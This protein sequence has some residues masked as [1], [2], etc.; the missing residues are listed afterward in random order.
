[1]LAERVAGRGMVVKRADTES[2]RGRLGPFYAR[3]RKV[4]GE[5]AWR[6]LEAQVGALG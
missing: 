6:L 1:M 5:E 4:F 3:W 2:F